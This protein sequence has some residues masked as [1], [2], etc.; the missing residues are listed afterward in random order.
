MNL[1]AFV[2]DHIAVIGWP[3]LLLFFWRASRYV[4]KFEERV[5]KTEE[6]I[7][8]MATNHLPHVEAALHDLKDAVERGFTNLGTQLLLVVKK[9]ND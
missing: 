1:I 5:V 8:T 7:Q 3:T 6:T 9:D 2:T 4:A